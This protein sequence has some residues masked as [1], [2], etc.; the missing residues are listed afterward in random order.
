MKKGIFLIVLS[1]LLIHS[2]TKGQGTIEL[3]EEII[4]QIDP[5]QD[6]HRESLFEVL[7]DMLNTPVHINQCD[8][9]ELISTYLFTPHQVSEILKYRKRY[10]DIEDLQEL[11]H[12]D[13]FTP[14]FIKSIGPFFVL[15]PSEKPTQYSGTRLKGHIISSNK[16]MSPQSKAYTDK[17]YYGTPFKHNLRARVR[18]RN[19]RIGIN[20]EKDPGESFYTS[21]LNKFTTHYSYF[22]N[23]KTNGVM[24][25]LILGNYKLLLG[26][27]IALTNTRTIQNPFSPQSGNKQMLIRPSNSSSEATDF[28]GFCTQLHHDNKNALIFFSYRSMH[29]N[30]DTNQFGKT[31]IRSIK[32]DGLFR[33]EKE[34]KKHNQLKELVTGINISKKWQYLKVGV[35]AYYQRFNTAFASDSSNM[36]KNGNFTGKENIAGSIHFNGIYKKWNYFGEYAM[37]K[38][39]SNA[40]VLGLALQAHPGLST[41]ITFRHFGREYQNFYSGGFKKLGGSGEE[42]GFTFYLHS[43]FIP[44]TE[45]FYRANLYKSTGPIFYSNQGV[46]YETH[47]LNILFHPRNDIQISLRYAY[48]KEEREVRETGEMKKTKLL[49]NN[50]FTLRVNI[51]AEA[52]LELRSTIMFRPLKKES[53]SSLLAQDFRLRPIGKD[54]SIDIRISLF[55]IQNWQDRLYLYEHDVLYAFS[56]PAFTDKGQRAYLNFKYRLFKELQIMAKIGIT[57]YTNKKEIGSGADLIS[58]NIKTEYN[59]LVKFSF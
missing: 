8:S 12:L 7:N 31:V 44:L 1:I 14:S 55:S 2:I 54:Y 53:Y 10:G 47:K 51:Q 28:R 40:L 42:Q 22:I 50:L 27:G 49:T 13:N 37:S 43:Q 4:E 32:K 41:G 11:S 17:L 52:W 39:L 45:V 16:Y 36:Y 30:A 15:N 46:E 6:Y 20:I 29:A 9:L 25:N 56:I 3:I 26:Q 19:Y 59:L 34:I 57:N 38:N 48:K 18:Y 24:K 5:D 33:T 21:A 35:L 23:Y 58:G